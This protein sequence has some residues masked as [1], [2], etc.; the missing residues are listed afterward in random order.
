MYINKAI[1]DLMK[2]K[3]VSLL[4]MAKALGKERNTR[5]L[6]SSAASRGKLHGREQRCQKK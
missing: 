6:D 4:T 1:R 5:K 3:N 2:A